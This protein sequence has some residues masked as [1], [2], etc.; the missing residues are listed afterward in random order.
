MKIDSNILLL[1]HLCAIIRFHLL[2]SKPKGSFV[3]GSTANS[4]ESTTPISPFQEA[5][6]DTLQSGAWLNV[7]LFIA[8]AGAM[9]FAV[10]VAVSGDGP[11]IPTLLTTIAWPPLLHLCFLAIVNNWVPIGHVFNPPIYHLRDTRLLTTKK[12]I[13]YPR[14]EVEEQLGSGKSFLGLC[15]SFAVPIVLFGALMGVVIL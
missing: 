11:T 6:R 12:G 4:S 8:T 5:Y 7:F 15:C 2:G 3:T 14:A 10:W 9:L 1:A 13:S